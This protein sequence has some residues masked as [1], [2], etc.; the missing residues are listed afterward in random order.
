M[1]I[2]PNPPLD[3]TISV[4]QTGHISD[5]QKLAVFANTVMS[6][7][8][9]KRKANQSIPN[10]VSTAIIWDD[11]EYQ[12]SSPAMWTAGSPTRLTVPA[13]G[14]Y[15]MGGTARWA[16]NATGKRSCQLLVSGNFNLTLDE[17][18]AGATGNPA[19]SL[20]GF[21]TMTAGAYL[22]MFVL[23]TSG[24]ALDIEDYGFDDVIRMWM[25]RVG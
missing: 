2:N 6:A 17:R 23:Q 12:N 13:D 18:P 22:E 19:C 15:L 3:E 8:T 10:N 16:F 1:S 4:G 21:H 25:K 24:G 9:L 5:H 14:E 11:L 7:A 20:S